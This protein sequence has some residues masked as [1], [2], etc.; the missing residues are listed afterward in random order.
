MVNNQKLVV[1]YIV[2]KS[3]EKTFESLVGNINFVTV[4]SND[5]ILKVESKNLVLAG[6][7]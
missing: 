3:G 1:H 6:V 4:G 7:R 2:E 5:G